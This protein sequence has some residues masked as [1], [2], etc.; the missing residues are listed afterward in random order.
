[1]VLLD[2]EHTYSIK[3]FIGQSTFE[4]PFF[5]CFKIILMSST[6]SHLPHEMNFQFKKQEKVVRSIKDTAFS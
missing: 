1:M 5:I 6:F 3:V 2:I 4:I